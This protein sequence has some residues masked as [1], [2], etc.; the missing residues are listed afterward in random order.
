MIKLVLKTLPLSVN[1]TYKRGVHA[2][3][4]SQEA[5]DAQEAMAWDARAQWKGA[6]LKTCLELSIHFFW[7]DMRRHDID[8]GLKAVIDSMTGIVY[9][10]DSQVC[11][12]VVKKSYDRE[13]PRVEVVISKG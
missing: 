9:E 1:A 5:K 11:G 10:D 8:N 6:P 12:L 2:F 13:A 3:Y 7:P 4:K